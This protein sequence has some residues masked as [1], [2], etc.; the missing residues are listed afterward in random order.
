VICCS[1]LPHSVLKDDAH[2]CM[3]VGDVDPKDRTKIPDTIEAYE[4]ALRKEG[5]TQI[6][7]VNK[8]PNSKFRWLMPV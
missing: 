5:I 8:R 6:S 2:I 1:K 7:E 3:I 4:T